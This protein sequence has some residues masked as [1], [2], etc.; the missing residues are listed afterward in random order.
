MR[1]RR[2]QWSFHTLPDGNWA[3]LVLNPDG[4]QASAEMA[5]R[6]FAECK[7]DAQRHGYIAVS[8]DAERRRSVDT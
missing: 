7:A 5:F 1:E 6:S 2:R 3:W 8:A 4:T